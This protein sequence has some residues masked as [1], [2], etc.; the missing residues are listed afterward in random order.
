MKNLY[1]VEEGED[2]TTIIIVDY[3]MPM[4]SGLETVK[5]IRALYNTVNERI[6]KN[7]R[8]ESDPA[9]GSPKRVV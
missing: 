3:E 7:Q 5:E 6:R 1:E 8:M 2:T 9:T 4:L